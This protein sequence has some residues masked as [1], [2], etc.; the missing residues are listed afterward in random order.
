MNNSTF[1]IAEFEGNSEI[2]ICRHSWTFMK[3]DE[4]FTYWPPCWRTASKLE[5][6]LRSDDPVDKKTWQVYGIKNLA[7]ASKYI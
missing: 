5:K 3:K 1:I 6:A 4:L 2:A 7:I